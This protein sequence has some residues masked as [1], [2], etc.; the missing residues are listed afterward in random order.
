MT[1]IRELISA[2][3]KEE[4]PE[5][6]LMI[7]KKAL[8]EAK[9]A[10]DPSLEAIILLEMAVVYKL[11][12][13]HEKEVECLHTAEKLVDAL[14][15]HPR[16]GALLSNL[17]KILRQRGEYKKSLHFLEKAL[18]LFDTDP[19]R[20]AIL[21]NLGNCYYELNQYKKAVKYYSTAKKTFG[22][23]YP[24]Q[25][26]ICL[27]NIGNTLREMNRFKKALKYYEEALEIF[28][29]HNFPLEAAHI[30]WNQ[31]IVY[32]ELEQFEKALF[33]YDQALFIIKDKPMDAAKIYNDKGVTLRKLT[34]YKESLQLLERALSLFEKYNM[35]VEV[36]EAKRNIAGVKRNMNLYEEALTALYSARKEL[37]NLGKPASVK[38]VEWEIANVYGSAGQS[39]AAMVYYDRVLNYFTEKPQK[40]FAAKVMRDKAAVL[41]DLGEYDEALNLCFQAERIFKEH[42]LPV[43]LASTMLN[44][45][46]LYRILNHFKDAQEI[47]ENAELLYQKIGMN[48][49]A[50]VAAFDRATALAGLLQY[51]GALSILQN[52]E[53]EFRECGQPVSVAETQINEAVILGE[54][55]RYKEAFQTLESAKRLLKAEMISH[56]LLIDLNESALLLETGASDEALHKLKSVSEKA[57]EVNLLTIAYKAYWAIGY[58]YERKGQFKN[59][60]YY[61][62]KCLRLLE[63]IRGDISPNL[64]KMSFFS[65]IEDIYRE[66]VFLAQRMGLDYTA[67]SVLQ[68]MKS[69][70][71][72]EQMTATQKSLST[73]HIPSKISELYSDL[74]KNPPVYEQIRETLNTINQLE[75]EYREMTIKGDLLKGITL[76]PP[77]AKVIQKQLDRKEALL[78]YI[79]GDNRLLLF[80]LTSSSFNS[81]VVE[82]EN[83]LTSKI[84]EYLSRVR[85]RSSL[86]NLSQVLYTML[87]APAEHHI[88]DYTVLHI[89]PDQN[90]HLFPFHALYHEKFLAESHQFMYHPAAVTI[91]SKFPSGDSMLVLGHAADLPGVQKECEI[92]SRLFK[93]SGRDCTLLLNKNATKETLYELCPQYDIIH[94]ACHGIFD[95]FNPL[96]SG[97][98][99]YDGI[100]TALELYQLDLNGRLLIFSACGSG[101][102]AIGK[103]N[104]LLGIT[105][106]LLC[107]GGITITNL[108]EVPDTASIAFWEA[109]YEHLLTEESILSA[110]QRAQQVMISTKF[111]HP[112]FWAGYRIMG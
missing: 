36:T 64:L 53:K 65:G 99:L 16:T 42:E 40:I 23:N 6:S 31:A 108:W 20:A 52:V 83:R 61:L 80:F 13:F 92:I 28:S 39:T 78:E 71:L 18:L 7:L 25:Y 49:H 9:N 11:L 88:S 67:F 68:K 54:L 4:S 3:R 103:G 59:A 96:R 82:Y 56:H 44:R 55:G 90:L 17:A 24:Y 41:K 91:K 10:E 62:E 85:S 102:V 33:C 50:A 107:A 76:T 109:F 94:I 105:R 74:H 43:E 47:F 45:G 89:V 77:H 97:L 51:K 69:R 95:S 46:N 14:P 81:I 86:R 106:A 72:I 100:L 66:M 84:Y 30:L 79:F 70:T 63:E 29:R 38:D 32:D 35:P 73:A 21:C 22:S 8:R 1:T 19:E 112:Y 57:V 37:E 101:S 34:R 87:I 5:E 98:N 48:G 60:Y 2:A 12:Q 27:Q 93:E 15:E 75:T 111:D 26:S 58:T 104:E 110:I